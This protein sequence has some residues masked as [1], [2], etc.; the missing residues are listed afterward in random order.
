MKRSILHRALFQLHLWAGLSLGIY[1]LLIGVTGS[2]L[3]FREEIVQRIT[4]D[5]V[6]DSSSAKVSLE[7][8]V[9]MIRFQRPDMNI[10]AIEAPRRA[11]APW[12]SYLLQQ[13]RP[14]QS[15]FID[16]T[17]RIVGQRQLEG[18]WF[19]LFER[20]HSN[21]LIR[22]GGRW[23]NGVA[24]LALA[25]LSLTGLYLWWPARG[26]W[27]RAFRVV[28]T[29]SWKGVIYDLHRVVGALT[30]AFTLLF[31]LTGAYFTWPAV[32]RNVIASVL[33]T[34]QKSP[35]QTVSQGPSRQPL[36][37]LVAAAQSAIPNGAL[38]RIVDVSAASQ[39]VRVVFRHGSI[40]E[41]YKTSEVA[42]DPISGAV[43]DVNRYADRK[44]G[45][46]LASFLGP[47]HTG[48]FSGLGVKILWASMGMVLPL[49]FLSGVV[50]WCNRIV[51]PA[52]ARRVRDLASAQS[53]SRTHV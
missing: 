27:S 37:T 22:N 31:C 11:D 15:V 13:G 52:L 10:W 32:Y 49:L 45:D 18:T 46:H 14:G 9:R 1:A 38:L 42:V 26:Q 20:F 33:P 28:R 16:T 21:L 39:P 40:E 6:I 30:L 43:L 12:S 36:D 35:P 50:M 41:N 23:Y 34:R 7:G 53:T 51:A 48:H 19:Q 5:P 47:L 29:S 25:A 2:V 4:P 17:G 44:P 8:M 24:G 3:V